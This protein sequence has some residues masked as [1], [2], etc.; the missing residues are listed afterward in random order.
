MLSKQ[1]NKPVST[2]T[3]L[4]RMCSK[5]AGYY[6]HSKYTEPHTSRRHIRYNYPTENPQQH[7]A[8]H[9]YSQPQSS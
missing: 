9:E 1:Q 4:R 2:R 5:F 8:K 6:C 7:Y 3:D